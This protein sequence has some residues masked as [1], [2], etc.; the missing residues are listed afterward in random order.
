MH[1]Q[2]ISAWRK[3]SHLSQGMFKLLQLLSPFAQKI[4]SEEKDIK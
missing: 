3:G 2:Q 4:S 1:K